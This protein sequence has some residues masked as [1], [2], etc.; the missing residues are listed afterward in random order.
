MKQ[1]DFSLVAGTIFLLVAIMHLSRILLQWQAMIGGVEIPMW[2]SWLG[3]GVAGYL[4]YAGI[5]IEK[6]K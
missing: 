1:K 4:A 6:K 5:S 2:V 3:V